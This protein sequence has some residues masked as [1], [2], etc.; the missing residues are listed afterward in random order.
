VEGSDSVTNVTVGNNTFSNIGNAG[1]GAY[2]CTSWTGNTIRGNSVSMSPTLLRVSYSVGQP[3]CG[4]P[5][6]SGGFSG[7][8]IFGNTFRNPIL[9]LPDTAWPGMYV[10]LS[11]G[12]VTGNLIQGNDLGANGGP[13]FYPLQGF[14]DGGGNICGPLN[15]AISNFACTGGGLV[16]HAAPVALSAWARSSR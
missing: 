13:Y 4:T 7:N 14:I 15:P 8:Q 11:Q 5:H 16:A 10:A 1:I 3:Q 2:W 12:T 9:G 6:P